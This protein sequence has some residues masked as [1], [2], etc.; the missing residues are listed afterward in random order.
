MGMFFKMDVILDTASDWL[1]VE[2]AA[3]T[4]CY[5]NTYDI[6]PSLDDGQALL[7]SK[8]GETLERSY[9]TMT[10]VGKEYTDTVCLLFSACVQGFEFFLIEY[11]SGLNEPM[12]G[13]LGL[14]R[15]NP[16]YLDPRSGNQTGPLFFEKLWKDG[17]ISDPIFALH[18]NSKSGDSWIDLGGPD[19]ST[20]ARG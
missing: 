9:G 1:L 14:A 4:N 11:Q 8:P 16:A 17:I 15:D 7:V 19:L 12:D 10:F 5:G 20:L 2:G 3:C 6:G 13:I 18:M